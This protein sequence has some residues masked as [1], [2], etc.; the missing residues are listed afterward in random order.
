MSSQPNCFICG[1]RVLGL[2]GQDIVL[3]TFYLQAHEEAADII[4]QNAFGEAHLKCFVGSQWSGAWAQCIAENLIHVRR[5][6]TLLNR[7]DLQILRNPKM[8]EVALIRAD[9]WIRF[10]SERSLGA[11]RSSPAGVSI[12]VKEEM[13][14]VLPENQ[15]LLGNLEQAFHA[16]QYAHLSELVVALGVADY[17]LF[18]DSIRAGAITP[19]RG[20]GPQPEPLR[21]LRGE[22]YLNAVFSYDEFVPAAVADSLLEAMRVRGID[23]ASSSGAVTQNEFIGIA[24]PGSSK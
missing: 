11:A 15:A 2:R 8:R 22:I 16:K 18:P 12:A 6:E 1:N 24:R 5:F 17:L 10:L 9:G 13:S 20:P 3:D 21:R 7:T 4:A 23:L 19:V 14:V